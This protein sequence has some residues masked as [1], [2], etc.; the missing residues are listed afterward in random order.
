MSV[1]RRVGSFP[2]E[3]TV[4]RAGGEQ[5]KGCLGQWGTGKGE[6]AQT[7]R[8][9]KKASVDQGKKGQGKFSRHEIEER[10]TVAKSCWASLTMLTFGEGFDPTTM[11]SQGR[12]LRVFFFFLIMRHFLFS[13]LGPT[14]TYLNEL[15][16]HFL[17]RN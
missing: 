16:L 2:K 4:G 7:A 15:R 11:E 17:T 3:G 10:L 8:T 1:G 9:F 5:R 14:W 12:I 13:P 6:L